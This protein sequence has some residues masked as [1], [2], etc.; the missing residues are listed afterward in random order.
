MR[1][2][3]LS[4][5]LFLVAAVALFP[6]VVIAVTNVWALQRD[7]RKALHDEALRTAELGA[8]EMERILSGVESVLRVTAA[9]PAIRSGRRETCSDVVRDMADAVEFLASMAIFNADGSPRCLPDRAGW[10]ADLGTRDHVREALASGRRVT[11]TFMSTGPR[12]PRVLPVALRIGGERGLPP[13][14]AVG[15]VD[16]DWLQK[17]LQER[18]LVEGDALTITDRDGTILA[19][20]PDPEKFIGSVIPPGYQYMLHQPKPESASVI[21]L[22]GVSR[23]LG[24][25]PLSSTPSDVFVSAGYATARGYALV[26]RVALRSGLIALAGI[27]A[28]FLLAYYTGRR[29]IGEPVQKLIGTVEAWRS[30]DTTVRTGMTAADGEIAGAGRAFDTFIEE[31]VANRRARLQSERQRDLMAGELEHR[32]KNLLATIQV[33]ARQTFP[34]AANAEALNAFAGRLQ[35]IGDANN[36]LRKQGWQGGSLHALVQSSIAPFVGDADARVSLSGPDLAIGSDVAVAI[37]MAVHELCTNAIKYGA[38]RDDAGTIA[39]TW[40]VDPSPKGAQFVLEWLE[41]DGPPVAEPLQT[42]FGSKVIKE[43]LASQ[44][45]GAVQIDYRPT[46]LFCRVTAPAAAV[47]AEGAAP[48]PDP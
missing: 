44:L 40:R 29:A 13:G 37:S 38:L 4:Q 28:A 22:D 43:A 26:R 33:I 46:G 21:G 18:N 27:V 7:S 47:L 41:R 2:R 12:G 1:L 19:R 15:Y 25:Y 9:A 45:G 8:L 31:L 17:R 11:G 32:V 42:G 23:I 16:L 10:P 20:R 34:R 35:V 30:G 36:L 39:V 24:Y 14:V 5:R 3:S 6:A 48:V